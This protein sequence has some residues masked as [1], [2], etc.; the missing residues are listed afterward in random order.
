MAGGRLLGKT[1]IPD[2]SMVVRPEG[3][4]LTYRR[5]GSLLTHRWREMDSNLRSP[6]DPLPYPSN[7]L[8]PP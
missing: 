7:Q 1:Q 6:T 3:R 2:K 5:D 4:P 8:G